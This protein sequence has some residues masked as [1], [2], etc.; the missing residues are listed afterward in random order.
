MF[1]AIC[2]FCIGE[3]GQLFSWGNG[4]YGRL[5][6]GDMEDQPSP[7]RVQ[8]LLGVR[9]RE[10]S[11]GGG[12]T[13]ALAE[14][15]LLYSWG[16]NWIYAVLGNRNVRKEMLPRP[17]EA[18]RSV[19]V[20][21]LAAADYRCYAVAETGQLWAWGDDDEGP[22][23][24]DALAPLGHGEPRPRP[25]SKPI[26]SLHD[27]KVVEVAAGTGHTLAMADD[28]SVYLWGNLSAAGSGALGLGPAVQPAGRH[29]RTPQLVPT[30]RVATAG[31]PVG[32][33]E[34]YGAA[35]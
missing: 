22:L 16:C 13:V 29:V 35:V 26:E 4:M 14:D 34:I 1:R 27:F 31:G 28:G 18:L 19:R 20:R 2:G 11:L 30:L 10:V 17:I 3:N 6:H 12:Y 32:C 25:L 24:Q 33:R 15:G 21:S 8:A 9:M 23:Y 7:T 5:G